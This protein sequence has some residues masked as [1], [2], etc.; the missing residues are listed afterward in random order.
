MSYGSYERKIREQDPK[1]MLSRLLKDRSLQDGFLSTA[2]ILWTVSSCN[3]TFCYQ[4]LASR[5]SQ[6]NLLLQILRLPEETRKDFPVVLQPPTFHIQKCHQL[7]L[8]CTSG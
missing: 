5:H 7:C 3:S 8:I 2:E 4:P 6:V 1:I